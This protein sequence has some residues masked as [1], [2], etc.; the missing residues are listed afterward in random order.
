MESSPIGTPSASSG[1]SGSLSALRPTLVEIPLLPQITDHGYLEFFTTTV[2]E[3]R[4]GLLFPQPRRLRHACTSALHC[5]C[6]FMPREQLRQPSRG[7]YFCRK[8][9]QRGSSS[10]LLIS[11]LYQ[12]LSHGTADDEAMQTH[13]HM[14]VR[15][16]WHHDGCRTSYRRGVHTCH[17]SCTA[18]LPTAA[19]TGAATRTTSAE[20]DA[21]ARAAAWTLGCAATCAAT[22]LTAQAARATSGCSLS[23]A[24]SCSS[25]LWSCR[26]NSASRGP[27]EAVSAGVTPVV[28]KCH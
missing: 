25:A 6:C 1:G 27:E 12:H 15:R 14:C 23:T 10:P 16:A 20:A 5:T 17:A 19:P 21:V 4:D 11:P 8:I 18:P 24:S 26:R 3:T 2:T 13:M 7:R 28:W 22:E 9:A